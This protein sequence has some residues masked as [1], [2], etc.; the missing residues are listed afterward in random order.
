MPGSGSITILPTGYVELLFPIIYQN[1]V[2]AKKIHPFENP[3]KNHSCFLSGLHTKPIKMKYN[4]FH[5]FGIRMRPVA[6]KALF[7][8]PLSEIRDYFIEGDNILNNVNMLVEKVN[9]LNNFSERARWFENFMLKKIN[10]TA[11]LH[12][13]INLDKAIKNHIIQKQNG[14]SKTMQDIMGYSRAQ[15]FRLFN[16]WFGISAH[17]YQKLLQFIRAT[18]SL[19]N[20]DAKL[21]DVG[22]KNGFYDQSHFIRTFKEFADMTPGE[23]RNQMTHLPLRLF[24]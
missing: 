16:A 7:S 2:E 24:G 22:F 15:T 4:H 13:A 8:K 23:Y 18:E 19:H 11:D 9:S 17:S 5:T 6:V 12:V 14:S 1:N 21:T 3:M 20:K 10:E